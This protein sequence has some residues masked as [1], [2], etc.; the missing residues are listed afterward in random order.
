VFDTPEKIHRVYDLKGSLIGRQASTKERENGGV[1]KD[2]DLVNDGKRLHLGS[3]KATFMSQ[4]KRD[5][6]FLAQ[7]N[8]MDYSLLVGIH[9]RDQRKAAGSAPRAVSDG[10]DGV[11]F[12]Q[13]GQHSN[14]P[15]RRRQSSHAENAPS[16]QQAPSSSTRATVSL[17]TSTALGGS[18]IAPAEG[19]SCS[20]AESPSVAG[21]PPAS[22]AMAA[23]TRKQLQPPFPSLVPL[24]LAL[25]SGSLPPESPA[26]VG[27]GASRKQSNA[28][29]TGQPGPGTAG[30]APG[31][32]REGALVHP[33]LHISV[34][35]K[36]GNVQFEGGAAD[37][38]RERRVARR[39][40]NLSS[41]DEGD[42]DE[43]DDEDDVLEEQEQELE[44]EQDDEHCDD[45]DS[46]S[47][48]I[49]V[50]S[51]A[52]GGSSRQFQFTALGGSGVQLGSGSGSG[53]LVSGVAVADA[54]QRLERA[55]TNKGWTGLEGSR[56]KRMVRKVDDDNDAVGLWT[57]KV[58]FGPGASQK[59]P[60]TRR[61]DGGINSRMPE[62]DTRGREIYFC[63]VIDILQQY[64]LRKRSETFFKSFTN[65]SKLISSVDAFTYATRFVRF[66]GDN[67]T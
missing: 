9:E 16:P 40:S 30:A 26:S 38:V 5:A 59:R 49:R 45:G 32:A 52:G 34:R 14:T 21:T 12:G 17:K 57:E 24:S 60:W 62:M 66:I 27:V 64:N 56:L 2:L 20:N 4:L 10:D 58:T 51:G 48:V 65:D 11:L 37:T 6:M 1:L 41:A 8:I 25:A 44:L 55:D 61:R 54:P 29:E 53:S 23:T 42:S 47:S 31:S 28:D 63:G 22:P 46:T 7:L 33:S 35:S 19:A 36:S 43:E 39:D 50:G 3:K 15:F 13:L 18:T 67:T